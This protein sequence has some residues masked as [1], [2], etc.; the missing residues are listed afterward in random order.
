MRLYLD[1]SAAAKLLVVEH[2][3]EAVAAFL[4]RSVD[5]GDVVGSSRLLETELRRMAIRLS[6]PQVHVTLLLER[7]DILVLDDGVFRDAGLLPGSSLRS[8][9]ALH[10]AAA[11]RWGASTMV[12]YDER[13]AVASRAVGLD[14]VAPA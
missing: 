3:S 4:D 2:G 5:A 9:D 13:L 10:V 7:L 11:L 12:A 1:T 8:L 14:V 6:I